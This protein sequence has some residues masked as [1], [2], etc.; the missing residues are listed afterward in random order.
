M[1]RILVYRFSAMGDVVMLLP[2]LKGLL[3]SNEDLEIYLLTRPFLFPVFEGTDRL[4]L[5]GADL[6]GQHKG[7]PGLYRLY[8]QLKKDINPDQVF[9]LHQVLRTRVLNFFF[10]GGRF[11]VHCLQKGR[12]EKKEAVQNKMH[13]QLPSTIDRYAA[14][15]SRAGFRFILEQPPLFPPGSRQEVLTLLKLDAGEWKV[16]IGIAPFARHKQ[17]VWGVDKI[18]SLLKRLSRIPSSKVIL[19]GGGKD[20]LQILDELAALFPN[21][22]VAGHYLKFADEIKLLPHLDLMVSMDSANMHLA[23]MAGIPV[24]SVWGATHPSL[25]FAPYHQPE[26]NQVQYKGDALNC[27]PCSVYGNKKCIYGDVRCM[28]YISVNQVAER[29]GFLLDHPLHH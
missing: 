21:C 1:K 23:A 19:F 6:K 28:K 26:A 2:V 5:V 4:H 16:L 22:L 24:V 18:R 7:V 29:V 20:E 17:K 11:D 10:R 15:F 14:A 3:E 12:S 9:D 8:R 13:K 25:G 27:R